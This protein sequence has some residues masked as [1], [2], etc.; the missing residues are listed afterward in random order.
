MTRL[1]IAVLLTLLSHVACAETVRI[2]TEGAYPPYNFI[3]DAGEIDGFER[4]LG[5]ELCH[6]ASLTCTWQTTDWDGM[7][8]NLQSRMY[9][10]I[11]AG[12]DITEERDRAIDFTQSYVPPAASVYAAPGAG[13]DYKTGRIAVQ[14]GTVQAEY[15]AKSGATALPFA[16]ADEAVAAVRDGTAA[17][18]FADRDFLAPVVAASDGA[19]VIVGTEV[20]IG[21]G[22]G[23][24]L[25]KDDVA[26]KER[27]NAGLTSMKADGSL[28]GLIRKWFGD[29][30]R[31]F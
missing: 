28:N 4:E 9:D 13:A 12:M 10:A 8:P 30:A 6:R 19:L 7:I 31:T 24:G 25:R 18:V 21:S 27:L 1:T 2:G 29:A 26:L 3:N 20:P 16:T 14:A 17:A 22:I 15:V 11:M 5:D 23:I